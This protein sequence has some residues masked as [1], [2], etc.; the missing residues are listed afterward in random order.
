MSTKTIETT[1]DQQIKLIDTFLRSQE[2]SLQDIAAQLVSAFHRGGRL[3]L[4]GTGPFGA[5]ASLVGQTFLHR[6]TIERPALPAVALT[7]DAGLAT[8]LAAED[9]ANQFFSRQ[10]RALAKTD[11]FVLIMAGT[12]LDLAQKEAISTAK[13]L[14][15]RTILIASQNMELSNLLPDYS[16][17]VPSDAEPRLHECALSIGNLLC[18]LV[19]SELFGI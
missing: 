9:Q 13:Q 8:F 7:N 5:I 14:G 19:E 2:K 15:C 12:F 6:Q 1:I 17:A 3:F 11:D 10:L 18:A 16:I 4:T